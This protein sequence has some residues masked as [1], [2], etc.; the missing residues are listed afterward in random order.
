[1]VTKSDILK[2]PA[3]LPNDIVSR[4]ID[5]KLLE[6]ITQR[7]INEFQPEEIYLFGSHAW[8]APD[9]SSDLDLLIIVSHSDLS[10]PQRTSRAYRCLRGFLMPIDILVKTCFEFNRF[11]DVYASLE[12]EIL[13]R[14]I[15]LYDRR[16]QVRVSAQLV[17][18]STA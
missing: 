17:D 15:L 5:K 13:D 10:P 2:K 1:M 14:G 9:E 4:Q 3:H 16:G 7:L 8:G 11:R 18:Q 12:A 6:E